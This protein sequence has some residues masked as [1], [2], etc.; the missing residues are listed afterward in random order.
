MVLKSAFQHDMHK[1]AVDQIIT[2]RVIYIDY[3]AMKE[4]K[5]LR[6][7]KVLQEIDDLRRMTYV[8]VHSSVYYDVIQ[9]CYKS[10]FS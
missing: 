8:L 5:P 4:H 3:L 7:I 10:N 9:E 1:T 2:D 6:L